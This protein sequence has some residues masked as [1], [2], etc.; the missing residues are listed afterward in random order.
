MTPSP[1]EQE[2]LAR[3]NLQITQLVRAMLGSIT[4]NMRA[5]AIA[6]Y[7][8]R[9]ALIFVLE[10]DRLEDREEVDDIVFEFEAL[11]SGYSKIEKIVY[12]D[13]RPFSEITIPG[14]YVYLR[15]E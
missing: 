14:E 9:L 8:D 7:K 6:F 12:I 4:T 3:E 11:Q 10:Q 13:S 2:T 1:V 15:H 5:V